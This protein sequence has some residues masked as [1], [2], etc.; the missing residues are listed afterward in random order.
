[1]RAADAEDAATLGRR[2]DAA[3][4]QQAAVEGDVIKFIPDS[5]QIYLR[6][7]EVII[8]T[9]R[10]GI[11]YLGSANVKVNVGIEVVQSGCMVTQLGD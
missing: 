1:M 4:A 5:Q 11:T 6:I 10:V 7:E 3:A 2:D 9:N 8:R